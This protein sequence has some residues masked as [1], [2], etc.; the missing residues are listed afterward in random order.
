MTFNHTYLSNKIF[1]NAFVNFF[2]IKLILMCVICLASKL[3]L[4]IVK[5]HF[6]SRM[7]QTHLFLCVGIYEILG[8][9]SSG[10]IFFLLGVHWELIYPLIWSARH[11]CLMSRLLD[12][13]I[14]WLDC[15]LTHDQICCVWSDKKWFGVA[16][17]K[18]KGLPCKYL[19]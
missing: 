7:W 1:E 17:L 16:P 13:K 14:K 8:R 10:N 2:F 9:Q 4:K 18:E 3:F 5:M 11:A 6:F 12:T 19:L 15:R